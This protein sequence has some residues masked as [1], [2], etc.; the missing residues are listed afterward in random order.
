MKYCQP[1]RVCV[2]LTVVYF[3]AVLSVGCAHAAKPKSSSAASKP[4][5][6]IAAT[7]YGQKIYVPVDADKNLKFAIAD[8]ESMLNRV[9]G[10]P[11]AVENKEPGNAAG[12]GIYLLKTASPL[13]P[14]TAV[15]KLKGKGREPFVI[16]SAAGNS[17]FIVANGDAGLSHGL[18]FYLEKLG[19]RWLAP[20]QNWEIAPRKNDIGVK[21]DEL[22]APE[23]GLRTFF[24]TGDLGKDLPIDPGPRE[25]MKNVVRWESWQRRNRYGGEYVLHGH[26]GEAFN[27]EKKAILLQHPEY[28]AEV[29]GKRVEWN[30]IAKLNTANPDAVKLYA[31]WS[32]AR[33]R[34]QR[35]A[36]P[37]AFA[38]SVDPSDGGGHCNS[39]ECKKIGNG[40]ASDQVYYVANQVAKAVRAEF[41]DGWVNL[42]GYYDHSAPPS[43][44]L[45]PNVYVAVIP[46]GFNK[47]GLEPEE[48]IRAWG[49][50]ASRI[51]LYDY[52]S[53]P[54]WDHDQPTFDFRNTPREKLRFWK[55][56]RVEGFMSEST[57]STGAMGPGWYVAARLMWDMKAD[58]K[59]V[60]DEWF[61]LGF[62]PAEKPM[63]RMMERWSGEFLLTGNELALSF[64]GL[65]EARSM[66]K[67]DAA[68]LRRI[69]DY[70]RY[71]EYLRMRYVLSMTQGD[72]ERTEAL[73]ALVRYVW[74]IYDTSMIHSFRLYQ[75]L[76][77]GRPELLAGY[78]AEAWGV[79]TDKN[80]P[81]WKGV[82]PVSDEDSFNNI[83]AQAKALVPLA[84]QMR[85]FRGGLVP[86]PATVSAPT[87]ANSGA[88]P[89]IFVGKLSLELQFGPKN[90]TLNF[91]IAAERD[92]RVELSDNTGTVLSSTIVPAGKEPRKASI[93]LPLAKGGRLRMN[94]IQEKNTLVSFVPP[95]DIK[96]TYLPFKTPKPY[97]S[98]G[99]YFYVPRG[100]KNVAIYE[101]LGLPASMQPVLTAP[102]G[103]R[104][105]G[106][107]SDGR[108]TLLY[109]V[110]AGMDGKCWRIERIV[111]PDFPIQILNAPNTFALSP[112]ALLVPSDSLR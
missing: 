57:Y 22:V 69:A 89:M 27:V 40:S 18:Y 31:D 23:F 32:V 17:L 46:Y 11:F 8:L 62:G 51:G 58:D 39:E 108:R 68:V 77:R 16:Q 48:F 82:S 66:A 19:V 81:L 43:F 91:S 111:A 24:G 71:V 106:Q 78:G 20:G 3:S 28:L 97:P 5:A 49:K 53:I 7:F 42:Y 73:H 67:G 88:T 85:D 64:R 14:K 74:S 90:K 96:V 30:E 98:S 83:E 50:K 25:T 56:N 4:Q 72:V 105:E 94:V 109:P 45:E 101:L 44:P 52:W 100:V 87:A 84:Y 6:K 34:E 35:K 103:T 55:D 95:Q 1:S 99:Y 61:R 102:D 15:Q 107:V 29:D 80:A 110:P 41:P 65:Q 33:F 86:L 60:L 12:A 54:D 9:T 26:S 36:D 2:A 47:S 13:A 59:A 70:G 10:R 63:R 93:P 38:V 112:D 21:L 75:L 79:P 37:Y 76:S 104:I 92:S